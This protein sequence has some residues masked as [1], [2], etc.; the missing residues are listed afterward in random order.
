MECGHNFS[1]CGNQITNN[2]DTFTGHG[3]HR[4]GCCHNCGE[5]YNGLFL[6][7]VHVFQLIRRFFDNPGKLFNVWCQHTAGNLT[8][9]QGGIFYQI[10]RDLSFAVFGF[11]FLQSRFCTACPSLNTGQHFIKLACRPACFYK[12]VFH[13]GNTVAQQNQ[14]RFCRLRR[15]EHIRKFQPLVICRG[16]D[17]SQH[18]AQGVALRHQVRETFPCFILQGFGNCAAGLVQLVQHAVHVSCAFGGSYAVGS[19]ERIAGTQLVKGYIRGVGGGD[20]FTHAAGKLCNRRFTK[21]LG[22]Y[23]VVG[24]VGYFVRFQLVSV[25]DCGQQ[26]QRVATVR[27]TSAGQISG[28]PYKIHGVTGLL[29]GTDRII[30]VLRD[31]PGRYA[32]FV[33]Q[34]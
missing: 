13:V 27:K 16:A 33:A 8:E 15:A 11:Q 20:D 32:A 31:F 26:V 22:C 14:A 4:A 24:N 30:Y 23:Q 28:V 10:E 3:Q 5:G 34:L 12:T 18:I 7:F 19:H 9:V 21:V 6:A 17:N 1:A 25:H 2:A 29:A